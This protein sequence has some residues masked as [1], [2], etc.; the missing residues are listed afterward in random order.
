MKTVVI[1]QARM[2]STRLPGKIL[3]PLGNS[4][5]LDYVVSRCKRISSAADVVVA[6]S[7]LEQ[8]DVVE[9]WCRGSGVSC[10]RGSEDDVLER[11]VEASAPYQPDFV[12]RVTGDCP[13][14]DYEFANDVINAMK[15]NPTDIVIFKGQNELP[16]GLNVELMS[17]EA[18]LR[19]HQAG[20]EP[21]HR[22][23]VTYY[24]YEYPDQFT[25]TLF[26]VPD[27]L[28]YPKL[29]I[30]LDTPEDY[31][32]CVAIA[33]AFPGQITVSSSG[34]ISYLLEHPEIVALNAHIEQKAV[35]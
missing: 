11:F 21:R 18:L 24:A 6:T 29:R 13:F 19:I 2:G 32:L 20:K 4:C 26:E 33:G 3:M 35:V 28:K 22:E 12:M 1:I 17:Y 25:R 15:A 10:Y 27:P 16:R 9:E 8:D 34:V 5:V 7:R 30:T 23:H 14:V 31:A